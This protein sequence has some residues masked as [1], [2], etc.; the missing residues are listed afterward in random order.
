LR[1]SLYHLPFPS[2]LR[3]ST[4]HLT[5]RHALPPSYLACPCHPRRLGA[6][7]WLLRHRRPNPR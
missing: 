3:P 7:T 1:F 2:P 5:R 4:S 6:A